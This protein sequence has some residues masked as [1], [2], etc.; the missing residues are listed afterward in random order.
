MK[1]GKQ[2][3]EL[4]LRTFHQYQIEITDVTGGLRFKIQCRWQ[5]CHFIF[6]SSKME[7][8]YI[9]ITGSNIRTS[10]EAEERKRQ[11]EEQTCKG[12]LIGSGKVEKLRPICS[13]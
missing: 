3:Q 13:R 5:A 6:S 1:K 10:R 11:E 7:S 4:V 9:D 2:S 8:K 12:L